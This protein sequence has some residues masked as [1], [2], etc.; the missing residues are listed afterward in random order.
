MTAFSILNVPALAF[1]CHAL[2]SFWK[3]GRRTSSRA[4]RA[5]TLQS[6]S[7]SRPRVFLVS[8]PLETLAGR[9]GAGS[10]IPF[11]EFEESLKE[12][13]TGTASLGN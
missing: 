11:P 3:E 12:I 5:S 9:H 8:T 10:P 2:T 13:R 7:E 4:N 1:M 6:G